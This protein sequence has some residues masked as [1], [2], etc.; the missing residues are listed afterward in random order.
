MAS[1]LMASQLIVSRLMAFRLMM[2]QPIISTKLSMNMSTYDSLSDRR[3][4]SLALGQ[5][6]QEPEPQDITQKDM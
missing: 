4:T 1:H 2:S 6:W 5:L 3:D